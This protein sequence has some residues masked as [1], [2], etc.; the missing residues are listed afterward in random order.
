M[1][2]PRNRLTGSLILIVAP[3]RG[4]RRNVAVVWCHHPRMR[5]IQYSRDAGV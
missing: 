5:V 4:S 1:S 3:Q 2:S